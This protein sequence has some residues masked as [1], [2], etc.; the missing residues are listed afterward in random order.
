VRIT[1]H[2]R[3]VVRLLPVKRQPIITARQVERELAG[4]AQLH[5]KIKP[6]PGWRALRDEGRE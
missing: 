5:K 3:E 4:L 2:G 1:R 6:G